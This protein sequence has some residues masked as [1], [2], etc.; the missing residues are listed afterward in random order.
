MHSVS[1]RFSSHC[2][3][4]ETTVISAPVKMMG[5]SQVLLTSFYDITVSKRLV[6]MPFHNCMTLWGQ[7]LGSKTHLFTHFNNSTQNS[8]G[9]LPLLSFHFPPHFLTGTNH[10]PTVE[11]SKPTSYLFFLQIS[12]LSVMGNRIRGDTNCNQ[13]LLKNLLLIKMLLARADN[14]TTFTYPFP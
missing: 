1:K 3:L 2:V 7:L 6:E 9:L 12:L 5:S 4:C 10:N 14:C 13:Y 8:T 11:I